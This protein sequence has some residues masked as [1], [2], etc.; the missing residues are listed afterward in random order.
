MLEQRPL[1]PSTHL[2][3]GMPA[4]GNNGW[5]LAG[6]PEAEGERFEAN[7]A[8][9]LVRDRVLIGYDGKGGRK[10]GGEGV[11]GEALVQVGGRLGGCRVGRV[12]RVAGGGPVGLGEFLAE[13]GLEGP[14][15][16]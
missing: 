10:H 2:M 11:L 16:D 1:Q 12:Q 8:I 3:Q 7:R 14:Q 9:I 13:V 4:L 6:E 15:G 5:P